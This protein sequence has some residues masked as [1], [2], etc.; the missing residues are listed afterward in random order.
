MK[1]FIQL[2]LKFKPTF[3]EGQNNQLVEELQL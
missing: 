1:K 3:P 2:S